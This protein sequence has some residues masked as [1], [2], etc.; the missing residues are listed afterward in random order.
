[1]L[2]NFLLGIGGLVFPNGDQQVPFQPQFCQN[3]RVFQDLEFYETFL[4]NSLPALDF[5]GLVQAVCCLVTS[6][7]KKQIAYKTAHNEIF[8]VE[9]YHNMILVLIHMLSSG[10][11]NKLRHKGDI[12]PFTQH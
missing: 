3:A 6:R 2:K 9:L 12:L 7:T 10:R 8:T 1:M 11:K 4:F 5:V